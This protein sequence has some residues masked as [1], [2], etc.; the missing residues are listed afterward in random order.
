[1]KSYFAGVA[2]AA[3]LVGGLALPGY[4]EDAVKPAPA[5]PQTEAPPPS[6]PRPSL[7]PK[8]A[9]P[10]AKTVPDERRHRRYAHRHYRRYAYWEP[11]P[12][13]W[14]HVDHNQIRWNRIP[15]AFRF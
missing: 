14:P 11:F 2:I 1:M 9:E 3:L 5:A 7:V 12:I 6:V 15:W 10:D 4:A 8:T 13:F